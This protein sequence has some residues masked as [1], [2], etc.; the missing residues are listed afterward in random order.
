MRKRYLNLL[1]NSHDSEQ[2][3]TEYEIYN[4]LR[5]A[6][7]G[8]QAAYDAIVEYYLNERESEYNEMNY[9]MI[10]PSVAML[11]ASDKPSKF[12]DSKIFS[13]AFI[14]FITGNPKSKIFFNEWSLFRGDWIENTYLKNFKYSIAPQLPRLVYQNHENDG[15]DDLAIDEYCPI[16]P[17][18]IVLFFGM[19]ELSGFRVNN[20]HIYNTDYNYLSLLNFYHSVKKEKIDEL[21]GDSVGL[22][23][24][25]VSTRWN[26]KILETKSLTIENIEQIESNKFVVDGVLKTF[27]NISVIHEILETCCKCYREFG[28]GGQRNTFG[29]MHLYFPKSD[30]PLKALGF[31][32]ANGHPKGQFFL[33]SKV[34]VCGS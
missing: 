30:F 7:M 25:I 14:K 12:A 29:R 16:S 26:S 6:R 33:I 2:S 4:V 10:T 21:F 19:D 18:S 23:G 9:P 22:L 8:S 13:D 3:I 15:F 32:G 31:Y 5:A 28:Y 17:L 20:G 24:Q 1:Q 11:T 34:N 27:W